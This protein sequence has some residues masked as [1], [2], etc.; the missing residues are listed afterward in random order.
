MS[1]KCKHNNNPNACYLCWLTPVD[2]I[3]LQID[4]VGG[5]MP[6]SEFALG[7]EYIIN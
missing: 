7:A 2:K 1:D 5:K 6:K 3:V 4:H